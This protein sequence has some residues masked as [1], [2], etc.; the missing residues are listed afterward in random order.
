MGRRESWW[1]GWEHNKATGQRDMR[2]KCVKLQRHCASNVFFIDQNSARQCF[3][4]TAPA[5][6]AGSL[7]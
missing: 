5:N 2:V 1:W 3:G 6:P 7:T 4:S